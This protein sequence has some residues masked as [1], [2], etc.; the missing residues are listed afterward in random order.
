MMVSSNF[1]RGVFKMKKFIFT[2]DSTE[3]VIKA[4]GMVDAITQV[5]QIVIDNGSDKSKLKFV[6]VKY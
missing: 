3:I 5:K 1:I 4:N 2:I 6:G